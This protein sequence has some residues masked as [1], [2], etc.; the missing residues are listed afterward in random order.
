MEGETGGGVGICLCREEKE[1][2]ACTVCR[3]QTSCVIKPQV[4]RAA[5]KSCGPAVRFY[6]PSAEHARPWKVRQWPDWDAVT[7]AGSF[8]SWEWRISRSWMDYVRIMKSFRSKM[9][10]DSLAI[11]TSSVSI[12]FPPLSLIPS[13]PASHFIS[14]ALRCAH[15]SFSLYCAVLLLFSVNSQCGNVER[16]LHRKQSP[17]RIALFMSRHCLAYKKGANAW[18]RR[19]WAESGLTDDMRI[20][21]LQAS[22]G[23]TQIHRDT[24]MMHACPWSHLKCPQPPSPISPPRLLEYKTSV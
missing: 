14:L 9:E 23:C 1:E 5:V 4:A 17:I 22:K 8:Q 18:I 12:F 6:W 2:S 10:E 24:H 13:I 11:I 19:R 3:K 16:N 21:H 7:E 20:L 15:T